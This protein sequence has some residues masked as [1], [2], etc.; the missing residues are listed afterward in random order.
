MEKV[1]ATW[2]GWVK[3]VR[4]NA[5]V[6]PYS[7]DARMDRTADIW[8]SVLRDRDERNASN[9]H[10]RNLSDSYYDFSKITHWFED[11]GVY[12]KVVN[13]STTTENVGFGSYACKDIDCTDEMIA[14]VRKTFDFFMSEK[15]YNGVHYRSLIQS[16]FTKIGFSVQVNTTSG[17]YYVVI[18]YIT[19]FS[20]K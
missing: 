17:R 1:R 16:N 9:V 18:H 4:V 3:D 14:A 6:P 2:L 10:R 8:A 12:A 15:S 20:D 13:R 5:G 7:Y 19:E 11:H